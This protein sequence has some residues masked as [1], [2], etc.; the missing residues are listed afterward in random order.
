MYHYRCYVIAAAFSHVEVEGRMHNEPVGAG[1]FRNIF[2]ITAIFNGIYGLGFFLAPKVLFSMSQDPGFPAPI[3]AGCG[4]PVAHSSG[5]RWAFGL[6]PMARLNSAL[7]L[8]LSQSVSDG[9][10]GV[11]GG[12][13]D[14]ALVVFQDFEP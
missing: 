11:A 9:F 1:A 7:S 2:R 6:L 14:C 13:K 3:L 4:G 8:L 10:L 12:G 5:L